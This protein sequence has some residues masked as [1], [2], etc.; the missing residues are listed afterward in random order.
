MN[1]RWAIVVALPILLSSMPAFAIV[2]V[3]SSTDQKA[4][5]GLSGT[6]SASISYQS[7]NINLLRLEGGSNLVYRYHEHTYILKGSYAFFGEYLNAP[8]PIIHKGFGHLRY[9]YRVEDW[10]QVESFIQGS[11]DKKLRIKLRLLYGFGLRFEY[12]FNSVDISTGTTYML[13]REVE[14]D[15]YWDYG[16]L[17]QL[18]NRWSNY[19]SVTWEVVDNLTVGTMNFFQPRFVRFCDYRFYNDVYL[20]VAANETLSMRLSYELQYD[21]EPWP[22]V[23]PIDRAIKTSLRLNF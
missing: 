7:G 1:F 9:R 8:S 2:N 4:Q 19:L 14:E 23:D 13:E 20:E 6:T 11:F 16:Q 18:V 3:M 12:K 21:S 10:F 5:V 17:G 22:S 15:D